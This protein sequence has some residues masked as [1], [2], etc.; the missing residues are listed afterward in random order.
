MHYG[1]GHPNAHLIQDQA[2]LGVDTFL[3][4]STDM[5]TQARIWLQR[6]RSRLFDKVLEAWQ[7]P[8][9]NPMSVNQAF[10]MA[11]RQGGLALRRPDLGVIRVGAKAD[12]VIFN[13]RSPA[14]LGW[15][16]PV[17]AV[18]LHASVGDIEH[19]LVDGKFKKRDGKLTFE[20]YDAVVERFLASAEK[21]QK[22]AVERPGPVLKGQFWGGCEFGHADEVNISRGSGTGYGKQFLHKH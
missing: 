6:T 15:R 7:I 4:F 1:H 10:L 18:I 9:N 2:A 14:M 16:D 3:T 8:V 12:L 21:I 11:T 20:N 13:G 19:V 5:L 22:A 17:A